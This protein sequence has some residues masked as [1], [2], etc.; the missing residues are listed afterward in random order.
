MTYSLSSYHLAH[1][2]PWISEH[3]RK[4]LSLLVYQLFL[5]I[6]IE[7]KWRVHQF[8]G[9]QS[10]QQDI[11]LLAFIQQKTRLESRVSVRQLIKITFIFKSQQYTAI[12]VIK[13]FFFFLLHSSFSLTV[14]LVCRKEFKTKRQN[15]E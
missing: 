12:R 1:P 15:Q 13:E 7:G 2:V 10:I 4:A 9:V 5:A 11:R 3:P 14:D 8:E 6:A